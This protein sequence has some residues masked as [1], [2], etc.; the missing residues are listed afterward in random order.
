MAAKT[1][2]KVTVDIGRAD[3]A[4]V[5]TALTGLGALAT[6][7]SDAADDPVW[8][9]SP[10][11]TPL[12]PNVSVSAWFDAGSDETADQAGCRRRDRCRVA[13]SDDAFRNRSADR[14]WIENWRRIPG[15]D[16]IRPVRR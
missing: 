4:P 10:G 7:L 14:D 12:W 16:E 13:L 8:E 11:M 6:A 9:P 5:E 15:A 2:I 3:P 1:W